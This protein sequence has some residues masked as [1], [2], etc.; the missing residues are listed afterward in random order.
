MT[1]VTGVGF[2]LAGHGRFHMGINGRAV[3]AQG[4]R[5]RA[6]NFAPQGPVL[7]FDSPGILKSM[8]RHKPWFNGELV[9]FAPPRI[10]ELIKQ[11]NEI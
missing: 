2:Q 6:M 10:M 11:C 5:W 7:D 4:Y 9:L 8:Q 1:C 3:R